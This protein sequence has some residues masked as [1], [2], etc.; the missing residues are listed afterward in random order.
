M[1]S[2]SL[3]LAALTAFVCSFFALPAHADPDYWTASAGM[4]MPRAMA[5]AV[6]LSD[7]RILVTGGNGGIENNR[8]RDTKNAEIYDPAA[9]TWT[10]VAAP[11]FIHEG[12]RGAALPDGRA[13]FVGGF[14]TSDGFILSETYDPI[15]NTWQVLSSEPREL[16]EDFTVT[17]LADG[18]VLVTGGRTR[19]GHTRLD[20][21][22][23][24]PATGSWISV[25]SMPNYGLR[26]TGTLLRD[27]RV[28]LFGGQTRDSSVAA[29]TP[30]IY[31][32]R[33]DT[34]TKGAL[35]F[36]AHTFHT[37]TLLQDGNVLIVAG[38]CVTTEYP[39]SFGAYQEA[40]A[41]PSEM[42][43][44][45][46]DSWTL[47]PPM[48]TGRRSHTATLLP[49]GKVLVTGGQ[50]RLHPDHYCTGGDAATFPCEETL[51]S[52]ETF[53]PSN[54]SWSDQAP[55]STPRLWHFASSLPDGKVLVVGG[56]RSNDCCSQSIGSAESYTPNSPHPK[57]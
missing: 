33:T 29:M 8:F 25:A 13:L 55:M 34:W 44:P 18:R 35:A 22:I 48:Q 2:R 17:P 4:S 26:Q 23:F 45:A 27:G 40:S 24:D 50:G 11:H 1:R 42:Y 30:L 10:L 5:S 6:T 3:S 20:A 49:N 37:A 21:D 41:Q 57:S 7:G 39:L 28:M 16:Y 38:C 31:D 14:E 43:D 12:S 54:R 36:S 56:F 32:P 15:A 9:G 51:S 47:L 52:T 19:F 53:D 46:T